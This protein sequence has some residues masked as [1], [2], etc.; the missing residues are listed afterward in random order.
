M[1]SKKSNISK[2]L[3][4]LRKCNHMSLEEAASRI[5][6]SRQAV[7][8]W[9]AAETVPDIL[10]CAKIAEL[11]DVSIDD[12]INYDA[13]DKKLGIPPKGKYMFGIVKLGEKGQIVIPKKARDKM[14][15]KPGDTFVVLG[16]D[17]SQ[18]RGIAIVP[19]EEFLSTAQTM[20][21]NFS[22]ASKENKEGE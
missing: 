12:L 1:N 17:E 20:L 7:S 6:V 10:N 14:R 22:S 18:M 5:G 13:D 11:Y 19:S 9:E 3:I 15:F 16:D 8:K 21:D 4:Y 2:N